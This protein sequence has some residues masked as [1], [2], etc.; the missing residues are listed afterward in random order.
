VQ[1]DKG[2]MATSGWRV[3]DFYDSIQEDEN[4]Q[5]YSSRLRVTAEKLVC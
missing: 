1:T 5:I 3:C 2:S 4:L